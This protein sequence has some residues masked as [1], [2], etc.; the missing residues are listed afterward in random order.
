MI[1]PQSKLREIASRRQRI[2]SSSGMTQLWICFF[3]V[4]II[5]FTLITYQTHLILTNKALDTRPMVFSSTMKN[6]GILE[7]KG[8]DAF[9][10]MPVIGSEFIHHT[11]HNNNNQNNNQ[12]T[13]SLA[14]QSQLQQGRHELNCP[15]ADLVS[16][17]KGPRAS[18]LLWESP[19]INI[20][21]KAK[22]VT[23]EPDPGGWNN[24][25]MQF[26][27]ILVFALATGRIFVLPPDQPMYLL[28]KGKGKANHHGFDDYFPFN[29]IKKRLPVI[30]MEEF[31][32]REGITGH[33]TK[34]DSV[35]VVYP[36]GNKTVFN[37]A[38]RDDRNSM[39]DYLREVS[40][41]P[42]WKPMKQYL[43]IPPQINTQDI[44][45]QSNLDINYKNDIINRRSIDSAGREPRFYDNY[46]QSQKVVHFISKPGLGYRL[47]QHF[48][49][50]IHFDDAKVDRL[51]K[52]FIR[53]YVHYVDLIFCKGAMIINELLKESEK[54][55]IPRYSAFHIR[56]GELQYKEVKIPAAKILE[57]IGHHLPAGQLIYIATDEKKKDF[58]DDFRKKFPTIRFL[59]D[60]FPL[61][62]LDEI[63]PNYLGMIDQVICTQGD[64]FVGT[65]FS[66]FT[67]YITRM[68]GYLGKHDHTVWLGD[69]KHMNRYQHDENPKFPFYMREW[70]LSW[71]DIDQD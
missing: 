5:F 18:D 4:G 48:Y 52:R 57:N 43:V 61:A 40:A 25:R 21:P 42:P 36:P 63:N 66:T 30:T 26:E 9:K 34:N 13:L 37:G 50:F 54:K 32:R 44:L 53:D 55:I 16:F 60:Y 65:W 56:R 23:F 11:T 7:R 8:I 22:Y 45:T 24:I 71:V 31:M 1:S 64:N 10:H 67:G 19:F 28:N 41:C 69:K 20:G 27:T 17:W 3:I 46:W 33:L 68:R 2:N 47:L 35:T 39:W 6:I 59:D 51:M 38:N 58:F 29:E 49:T 70:N 12:N 15:N 14:I 62:K